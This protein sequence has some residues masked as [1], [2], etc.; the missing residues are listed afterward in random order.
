MSLSGFPHSR[1]SRLARGVIS[2]QNGHILCDPTCWTGGASVVRNFPNRSA[3][4]ASLLRSRFRNEPLYVGWTGSIGSP[5]LDFGPDSAL[6]RRIK[7]VRIID[8]AGH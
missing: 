6:I 2:P 8:S 5:S 1:Q 7:G 4:E 3:I